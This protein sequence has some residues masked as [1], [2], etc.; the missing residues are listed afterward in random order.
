MDAT[1]GRPWNQERYHQIEAEVRNYLVNDLNFHDKLVRCLPLSGYSG[2]NLITMYNE[3]PGKAWYEGITL[4]SALDTFYIPPKQI[5]KAFR[6]VVTENKQVSK[7]EIEMQIVVLQGKVQ[8]GRTVGIASYSNQHC[9]TMA[10]T[11]SSIKS[12]SF[13]S[14][15]EIPAELT[16]VSARERAT[17]RII[18]RLV[19]M[20][21]CYFGRFLLNCGFQTNWGC[22]VI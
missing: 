13:E 2:D 5:D 18:S 15:T 21:H 14:E 11:V 8:K 4:Q 3:C 22:G 6:A 16:L 19:Y 10:G 7:N 1:S 9:K 20:Q 12:L 17:V